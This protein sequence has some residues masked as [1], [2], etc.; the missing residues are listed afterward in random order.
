[1]LIFFPE[2]CYYSS[3]SWR[4]LHHSKWRWNVPQHSRYEML[5]AQVISSHAKRAACLTV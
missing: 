3:E 1:M 5:F 2:H 4:N